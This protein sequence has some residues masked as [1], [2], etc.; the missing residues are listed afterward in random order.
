[1][2]CNKQIAEFFFTKVT[3]MTHSFVC[4][5]GKV[6]KQE[7]SRRYRNLLDHVKN[8]HPDWENQIK[9]KTSSIVSEEATTLFGWLDWIVMDSLPF[10]TVQ[11]YQTR[12][13]WKLNDLDRKTLVKYIEKLTVLVEETVAQE[14]PEKFGLIIDGWTDS[15]TS[16]HYLAI[17]ACYPD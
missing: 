10:V 14:L 13:F 3:G 4:K 17:F 9:M 6:R 1:M 15:G 8:D 2:V 11:K 7:I 16:T 12:K 5:C